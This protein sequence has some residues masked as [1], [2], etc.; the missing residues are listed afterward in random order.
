MKESLINRDRAIVANDQSAK[1]TEPSQGAFHFPAPP[2]APQRSPI[3]PAR[4]AAV[5]AVRCDQL[6]S[7]CR[8]PLPQ[9]VAVIGTIRNDTPGFLAGSPAATPARLAGIRSL[10]GRI[11]SINPS[12]LEVTTYTTIGTFA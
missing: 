10:P 5:P 9:W 11:S 3:L 4:L 8:Q 7:S 2:V 6:D 1:V 12:L